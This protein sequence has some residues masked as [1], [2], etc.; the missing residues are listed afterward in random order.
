[1]TYKMFSVKK[2]SQAE[3]KQQSIGIKSFSSNTA[4]VHL[5]IKMFIKRKTTLEKVYAYRM[6]LSFKTSELN[7]F[8]FMG[9]SCVRYEAASVGITQKMFDVRW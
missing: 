8:N 7:F 9:D 1:M 6:L 4:L 5:S 3:Q 2:L